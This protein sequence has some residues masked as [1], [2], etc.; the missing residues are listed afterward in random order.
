MIRRLVFTYL[1]LVLLVLLALA[2]PLGYLY[3]RS[4][5]QQTFRQLEREAAVLAAQ[6]SAGPA[7]IEDLA[8]ESARRWDGLV[9]VFDSAGRLL[10][11]TRPGGTGVAPDADRANDY[12]F[13]KAGGVPMMSVT[14]A[15]PPGRD[16][17]G[18]VRLSSPTAPVDEA[19]Y[20]FWALLAVACT[21]VLAVSAAVAVGLATWIT[22]PVRALESATRQLA[23]GDSAP[24]PVRLGGPPEL[25]RL[26]ET[27]NRTALRL[28]SVL[29][30]RGSFVEHASH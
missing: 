16:T 22:R 7:Q 2:I 24:A 13:T 15:F 5:Q 18:A 23:D 30:A 4:E 14:V 25:R 8:A 9:E 3:Q 19:V 10:F 1:S 6:V 17:S 21:L 12:G 11:S 20:Q 26:A 29:A 28:H 27:F